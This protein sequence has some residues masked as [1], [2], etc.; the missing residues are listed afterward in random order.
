MKTIFAAL[1]VL[2]LGCA[3]LW[4]A[5]RIPPGG[6]QSITEQTGGLLVGSVVIGLLWELAA[7]RSFRDDILATSK[8]A[9]QI[10]A[11]GLTWAGEW[12]RVDFNDLLRGTQSLEIFFAYGDTWRKNNHVN[13][14][15]LLASP[16]AKLKVYLPDPKVESVMTTMAA[17]FELSKAELK[18]KIVDSAAEFSKLSTTEG[19]SVEVKYFP[20]DS[21]FSCYKFDSKTALMTLYS[22][23]R[24]RGS[25]PALQ[26][27]AGGTLFAFLDDQL[28]S[29]DRESRTAS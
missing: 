9:S 7:K 16:G 1:I 22:H 12:S 23:K 6:W 13:L 14:Q 11:V 28:A 2:A 17:R 3:L 8:L 18:K 27:E 10:D 4:L 19:G 25:V 21:T 24:E 20:R 15:N 5:S 29:V 26:C